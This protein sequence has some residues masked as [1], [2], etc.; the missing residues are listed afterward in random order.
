MNTM[1][2]VK[3]IFFIL[4]LLW[5]FYYNEQNIQLM[6]GFDSIY[7]V[8]GML[9]LYNLVLVILGWVKYNIYANHAPCSMLSR[10][11]ES[12]IFTRPG[13]SSS[14]VI[15]MS[16]RSDEMSLNSISSWWNTAAPCSV[17]CGKSIL[18]VVFLYGKGSEHWL[19]VSWG[20]SWRHKC[21]SGIGS[22]D[23]TM[24]SNG[25]VGKSSLEEAV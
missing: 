13:M 25:A 11:S 16:G 15:I 18:K 24:S 3:C 8:H 10:C 12:K 21:L 2:M 22:S 7:N 20:V 19:V 14:L 17:D 23:Q 5:L 9:N 4:P 1:F 6:S